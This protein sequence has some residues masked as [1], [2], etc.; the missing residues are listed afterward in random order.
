M[1]RVLRRFLL[2]VALVALFALVGR[3]NHAETL[4]LSGWW[5]TFW[6]FGF[7]LAFG[8]LLLLRGRLTAGADAPA[9]GADLKDGALLLGT[10]VVGGML[11]RS[12]IGEG[13]ATS[14]VVVATIVLGLLL[15]GS[16]VPGRVRARG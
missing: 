13:T 5:E 15:L 10:T 3:L 8:W 1:E 2:D 12:G 16:R 14:F 7:G 11:I 4:S 9:A 6:P